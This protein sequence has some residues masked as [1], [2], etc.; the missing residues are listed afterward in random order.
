MLEWD[1]CGF[2]NTHIGTSYVKLV[3]FVSGGICGSCSALR[4]IRGAKG[5]CT[6]FHAC[7]GSEWIPQKS[8]RDTLLQTC[9]LLSVGCVGH[10]MHSV[11]PRWKTS[12]HYF[13]CSCGTGID[14]RKSA[15]EH[16]TP[17]LCFCIRWDLWVTQW[18][19]QCVK[20]GRT[21]FHAR[22]GLVRFS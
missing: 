1:W 20:C 3:C 7:L 15:P 2:H 9:V 18:C 16:V 19:I 5:R 22:V 6:I 21:I 11:R 4:C 17:N 12:T 8:H 10:V 14:S 13:S